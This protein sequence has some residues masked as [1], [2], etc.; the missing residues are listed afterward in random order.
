MLVIKRNSAARD[1]I[2]CWQI[3]RI[4]MG[5]VELICPKSKCHLKVLINSYGVFSNT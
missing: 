3:G 4:Q 1:V 5:S 2:S